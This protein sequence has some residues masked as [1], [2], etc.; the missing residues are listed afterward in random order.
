MGSIRPAGWLR[1][2]LRTQASG[3][4][5]YLDEF[6]PDVR[7]SG[8]IG[9]AA[10]GWE[11]GP[12]WL[13]GLVP[14][15]A[16]VASPELLGKVDRWVTYIMDHQAADGWLGPE[17]DTATGRY[18]RRDP[19]PLF[20]VLKALT[21]WQDWF[22]DERV[23]P[24]ITRALRCLD[25]ELD[26]RPLYS[27][28]AMRWPDLV[29]TIHWLYDRTH[30]QWLLDLAEKAKRQGYDWQAHFADLPYKTKAKPDELSLA[31][32][33]VNNAMAIKAHAVWWRQSGEEVDRTGTQHAI[34]EL[35]RYHGQATGVFSGD[36][37]LAGKSPSQGTELC[38]VVEYM[39]SLE[40]SIA[41]LGDPSL[42]DRLERIAFN[43]LPGTFSV[44]M[45]SH[46]YDQQANQVLCAVLED[47]V[48]TSNGPDANIFGLEPNYGCCTAN[49]H[50]G[51]P[52]FVHSLWMETPD[53]GLAAVSYAPCE[54][55]HER[56]DG[57][58]VRL[59]VDGDYPFDEHVSITV[60]VDQPQSFTLYLRIPGWCEGATIEGDGWTRKNLTPGRFVPIARSWEGTSTIELHM[61]MPIKAEE[62][63]H[64]SVTLT[65]GPVVLS[66]SIP[67]QW[68]LIGGD[69]PHANYEVRP[70]EAFNVGLC[71]DRA[72]PGASLEVLTFEPAWRPYSDVYPPYEVYARARRVPGWR[73]SHNAAAPPPHSPARAQ[74]EEFQVRLI[75]YGCARLRITE[76]PTV[77]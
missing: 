23:I 47:N 46:Q 21:Q 71:L 53:G 31:N 45:W 14:M 68:K 61:P 32:H 42:A 48:Y 43:A 17:Q 1:D 74:G 57:A 22:G 75:P 60:E 12:Y 19:W 67:E 33:V 35:D 13:D 56:Q 66:M 6:W 39:F 7:D 58:A 8:W 30:E 11:R 24:V 59:Y 54:V 49:M 51:W 9:G 18:E 28:S 52:K 10:E 37:H 26:K 5:G 16:A 38:A 3:L 50:Q 29:L 62:R 55:L 34:A 36:E 72:H 69:P 73:W 64:G 20:I 2:Q 76:F 70:L 63:Y 77:E 41:I 25:V 44:D 40:T 27:W 65:R 4:S 15:A